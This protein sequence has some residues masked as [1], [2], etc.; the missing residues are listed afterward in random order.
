MRCD[1]LSSFV[2][3][4]SVGCSAVVA[5]VL[6]TAGSARAQ[7]VADVVIDDVVPPGG[8]S[9]FLVPFEVPPGTV[10]LEVRHDIVDGA[11]DDVLDF[12][13]EDAA[14]SFRGWG[15]GNREPAIV[16]ELAA[17][18][19]YV[20][21]AMP[22][23]TWHVV[24]GKARLSA[25]APRFHVEVFLRSAATLPTDGDQAQT[26][27]GALSAVLSTTARWYA[28]DLHVH[29]RDSGDARPDLD[30]VATFARGRGLDFVV[31]TDHN[32]NAQVAHL[33]EA[34]ARHPALLLV[35]G[36]E[37][38][39]YAGHAGGF[40][41]IDYVD[42]K[43]GLST[44]VQAAVDAIHAQG[45]L[46]SINHPVLDLGDLCIGCAWTSE[47]PAAL[48]G[49]E[50]ATGGY[51]QS[52]FLFGQGARD[53]WDV[54]LD[55]GSRAAPLGGSDDHRAGADIEAFGSPIGDPTTMIFADEQ[56]TRALLHG[57]RCNRTVV[58]LQGPNDPMIDLQTTP[59]RACD[60][61]TVGVGGS[62]VL[63]ATITGGHG[64]R[65]RLL[66]DGYADGDVVDVDDDPF[67]LE[68]TVTVDARPDSAE[69]W[70]VEVLDDDT[71]RVVSGHV[72]LA[73]I[74]SD[75]ATGCGCQGADVTPLAG[76]A[77]VMLLRRRRRCAP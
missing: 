10:E 26:S 55:G 56:S 39:T 75:E 68:R 38:T 5:A 60:Q 20:P 49:V 32:T 37:F 63:R 40:G 58:K 62:V 33:D 70:R 48:D 54:L 77:L 69:R 41:V 6:A 73:A 30:E 14:G 45:G 22:A 18:R 64:F 24:I 52:G 59:E 29:S 9:F 65:A 15:G 4:C 66:K 21:G 8:A 11:D 31:I 16:G 43:I 23:G 12:G 17:S 28:G 7:G 25:S 51:S 71:P 35:P 50:I 44:T 27:S 46:F 61:V 53:F 13:L 34:Q 72:W 67:V 76:V 36:V 3:V 74:A 42:H 1:R 57:I 19:S 2:V 47:V